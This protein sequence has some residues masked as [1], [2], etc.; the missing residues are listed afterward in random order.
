MCQEEVRDY[1]KQSLNHI[2]D[3]V[4]ID[5]IKW[6]MNRHI[7]D[8]YS[9]SL[10]HQGMFFHT[11]ILGLYDILKD[12]QKSYPNLLIET[13]SSG[14][15]RFDLG[16]LTFSAQ[17]WASDDT[18]PIER[19]SIQEGLSYF[20]PLSTISAHVSLA[21][22]AQTLRDTPLETRFNVASFGVLGY[23]LNFDYV[24]PVEKEEM[25]R[26]IAY[27]KEHRKLFQY[28]T[29]RR[30]EKKDHDHLTWQVSNEETIILGQFQKMV[31]ASPGFDKLICLDVE[32]DAMYHVA[33][34]KQRLPLKRFGHLISHALPIK[35][36]TNGWVMR[37]IGK[38]KMLD[39][40]SI[41]QHVSGEILKQ[42]MKLKQQ[43]MGTYYNDQTRILGDYGSMLYEIKKVKVGESS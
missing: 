12:I 15:N 32:A 8:M 43:F 6:D 22:H 36:N 3:E 10:E 18:D 42:G 33:N 31:S 41:D 19:L 34:F 23:E 25:K 7:T 2:L 13:C 24:S 37:T 35:L 11:Y 1:I 28:G 29:F 17:V 21:P 14:G 9:K 4:S 26:Q 39:N 16:M 27:Y 30:H 20:Y 5:Y 40:A 38:Y